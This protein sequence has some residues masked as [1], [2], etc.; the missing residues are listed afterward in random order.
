[1][2]YTLALASAFLVVSMIGTP[3]GDRS[4]ATADD[5]PAGPDRFTVV[6]QTYTSYEW[7]LT[8]WKDNKVACSLDVDHEGLPTRGEIYA[9]CG[10]AVYEAWA[11]TQACSDDEPCSG[12]YLQFV[13]SEPAQRQVSVQLPPPAVWVN[14][15][16]CVPVHSTFQCDNLPTLVLTGEEPLPG[17]HI[18]GLAGTIG[19]RP[20]TC[21]AVCQV[22]LIPTGPDGIDLTFWALSSYGDTSVAFHARVRLMASDTGI[23]H[24]YYADVLSTQWRGVPLAGCS[25]AW[26]SF[27]TFGGVPVWL[28][29]PQRAEDLATDL[30]YEYLAGH[31]IQ[32]G[33]VDVSGCADGG[34]LDPGSASACG[35]EAAQ[36]MV[37]DWQNRFDSLIFTAAI[38]TGIPAE[39]LKRIFARESQFWPGIVVG[40]P[41]AGLGQMTEGG[42]DT[43]LMWN[44]PFFE[45]FCPGILDDVNC[46]KGYTHLEEDQQQTL[47]TALVKSVDAFCTDCP[48]GIDL[49]RAENSVAVFSETL[50]ANCNQAGMIVQNTYGGA[51]GESAGFEDL[52]R[53][54][55]VNYNAGPGCL[56]LAIQANKRAGDPLDW[57]NLSSHLTPACLGALDYVNQISGA[58]P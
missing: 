38:S 37:K 51:A 25:E 50:L 4:F 20:F 19:D 11:G 7:W 57:Q 6:T 53:L 22:D 1:M 45:Q 14:L 3:F 49:G 13:K 24:T 18:T 29:T 2:R 34:L 5:G 8:G 58:G 42:A 43:T 39:L 9:A 28:D 56:T 47:R 55:L 32:Q 15:D 16:G 46:R 40:H 17:E 21:D 36:P 23:A 41:E 52:W 12:Y 26:Q 44:Q 35:S 31:L 30:P 27:P 10:E 48:L 33:L 54:A